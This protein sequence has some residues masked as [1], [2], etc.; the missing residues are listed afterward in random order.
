MDEDDVR[1][2]AVALARRITADGE[3][4]VCIPKNVAESFTQTGLLKCMT[5]ASEKGLRYVN[6]IEEAWQ[7]RLDACEMHRL[8]LFVGCGCVVSLLL[9]IMVW[10]CCANCSKT[11]AARRKLKVANASAAAK[12]LEIQRLQLALARCQPRT[13]VENENVSVSFEDLKIDESEVSEPQKP[14]SS[15]CFGCLC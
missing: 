5:L 9:L 11:T 3:E 10:N 8:V 1:S 15:N 14:Q 4:A 12:D 2:E 7:E 6:K 13:G